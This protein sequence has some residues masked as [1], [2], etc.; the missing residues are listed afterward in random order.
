MSE[1]DWD[2]ITFVKKFKQLDL[3]KKKVTIQ[4]SNPSVYIKNLIL[5][6]WMETIRK[7]QKRYPNNWPW[8]Y[9]KPA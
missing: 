2:P 7:L 9:R 3:K 4:N 5:I 8:R 6:N 1:Q